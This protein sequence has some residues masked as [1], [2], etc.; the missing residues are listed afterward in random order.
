MEAGEQDG[1][2]QCSDS[3]KDTD[4]KITLQSIGE[5]RGASVIN[6]RSAARAAGKDVQVDMAVRVVPDLSHSTV[7]LVV[8]VSY[9]SQSK[10]LRERLLTCSAFATFMIENLREYVVIN[11]DDVIVGGN[12]MMTMLG[13]AVGALRGIVSVRIAG[14]PLSNRPLPII[15]L[16]ALMYRLSYGSAPSVHMRT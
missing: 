15:D 13:I 10:Y 4:V 16:T 2:K 11:G 5:V 8:T 7:S 14:T 1:G 3:M 6:R 12:L 9:I